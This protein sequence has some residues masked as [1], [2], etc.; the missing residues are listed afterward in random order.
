MGSF[1]LSW[2]LKV[3]QLLGRGQRRV[4]IVVVICAHHTDASLLANILKELTQGLPGTLQEPCPCQPV[5]LKN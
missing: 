5:N 2:E 4:V 1:S 3:V